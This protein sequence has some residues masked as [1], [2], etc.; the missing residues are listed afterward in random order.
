MFFLKKKTSDTCKTRLG[1]DEDG[2][3]LG[4][5]DESTKK[6]IFVKKCPHCQ[7]GRRCLNE[8]ESMGETNKKPQAQI[9][10]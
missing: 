6:K 3:Y 4:D 2:K 5:L 1:K 10:F 9:I 7:V 8:I